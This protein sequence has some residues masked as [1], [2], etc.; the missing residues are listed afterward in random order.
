[1][2]RSTG[3]P[4][5]MLCG[6]LSVIWAGCIAPESG[7]AG[8]GESWQVR[9]FTADVT[10][11]VEG[12]WSTA[13]VEFSG[14]VSIMDRDGEMRNAYEFRI[15]ADGRVPIVE[16]YDREFHMFR[17]T[18]ECRPVECMDE[19][20][21]SRQ[22]AL[23]RYGLGFTVIAGASATVMDGRSGIWEG[24]EY[25]LR[26]EAGATIMEISEETA[27]NSL[28]GRI[29][30]YGEGHILPDVGDQVVHSY[31]ER[32]LLELA[33]VAP[34]K[35]RAVS[36]GGQR[37]FPGSEHAP[38]MDGRSVDDFLSA[39]AAQDAAFRDGLDQGCIEKIELS[40]PTTNGASFIASSRQRARIS[41]VVDDEVL[42][43]TMEASWSSIQEPVYAIE[44]EAPEQA[45]GDCLASALR[46]PS[47]MS[48]SAWA[49]MAQRASTAGTPFS[50]VYSD[51]GKVF[52]WGRNLT[53]GAGHYLMRLQPE[54]NGEAIQTWTNHDIAVSAHDGM[55]EFTR[56][57][58]G[59]IP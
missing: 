7:D 24:V 48:E 6:L 37:P 43:W 18:R 25:T 38:F 28:P 47:I 14:P 32:G 40:M 36:S 27:P 2:R 55:L 29:L 41:L 49:W 12:V 52:T 10:L 58:Q 34:H 56:L 31:V 3:G 26:H 8:H 33:D 13:Q 51:L 23:S 11:L 19:H 4:A 20:Y 53:A 50:Y 54:S 45:S 1:M 46:P 16:H 57:P 15:E 21:W 5:V 22:G 44:E 42:S 9:G 59:A 17:H 35:E 30:S 39:L